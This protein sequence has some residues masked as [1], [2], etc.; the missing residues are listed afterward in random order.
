[1]NI[2]L[3]LFRGD[4]DKSSKFNKEVNGIDFVEGRKETKP[5]K[6][7]SILPALIK[8]FGGTFL[9][10]TFLQTVEVL[11]GFVSPELLK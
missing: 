6:Q 2:Y 8:A 9:F 4:V 10:G 3:F 5:K 7:A 1:M 11:L